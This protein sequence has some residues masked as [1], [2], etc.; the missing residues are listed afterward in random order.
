MNCVQTG[1]KTISTF[2]RLLILMVVLVASVGI[3]QSKNPKKKAIPRHPAS[4]STSETVRGN[5][6]P[7]YGSLPLSFEANQGQ[8]DAAV[9]YIS[10][11]DG[12]ALFLTGTGAVMALQGKVGGEGPLQKV[13][14]KT[15]N[16]WENRKIGRRLARLNKSHANHVLRLGL[17]GAKVD[18]FLAPLDELPGKSNYF[19][20]KDPSKWRSGVPNYARVRDVGVYPGVDLIYYGNQRQLEFDFVISPGADPKAIALKFGSGERLSVMRHGSLRIGSSP[21]FIV[22]HRPSIYQVAKGKKHSVSGGFR[23]LADGRVGFHVGL[24]NHSEPLI[25]DPVLSYSTFLS[26]NSGA[27][28]DGIAV[29]SSGNGYIAGSTISTD[30]PM[31]NAYQSGGITNFVAFL[32]KFDPT[33]TTLL[34]ST[35]LGG[36]GESYS[37]GVAIDGS[38]NAYV[39]GYTFTSAFPIVNGLQT[40]NNN[41]TGGNAFVARI[42][43][44]QVGI[45]SLVYSTYLG[46]GG[47]ASSWGDTGYGI[48]T[49]QQGRAYVTGQTTSDASIVPFPTTA[50]A[51]Q[52]SSTSSNGTAFLSVID[53]NLSGG[54]SLI[55]STYFGGDGLGPYGEFGTGIAVDGNGN[56]YLVGQTTSDSA[57]PFPTTPGAFQTSL[58]SPN[59]NAF[60]AEITPNASG[61]QSLLYS[62]YL[63]GSTT[64]PGGD[65]A[66]AIALDPA[67][68]VYVVGDTSSE[69]F[70]VTS[71]VFQTTNSAVGRAFLAKLDLSQQGTQALVYSTFLG[72]TNGDYAWGVTV[73]GSGNS[74]VVGQT[75]SSDFPTTSDALQSANK[76]S[77]WTGF[78][79]ELSTDAT[80]LLYSTYLGGTIGDVA[81][82]VALDQLGNFY[83]A[84]YTDSSDFPTANAFQSTLQ[85]TQGGFVT[86]FALR[87]NPSI[88]ASVIPTPNAGGWNN[89]AATV[90][91]TCTPGPVLLQT[92]SP[93]VMVRKEGANQ[94]FSGTVV[95]TANTTASTTENVS[96]DMTPPGIT[97]TSPVDSSSVSTGTVLVSGSIT[98]ALSGPGGVNCHGAQAILNGSAFSCAVQ[99]SAGSNSI[100]VIGTD[101]AGNATSAN[102]TVTNTGAS[103]QGNPPIVSA[104]SPNL[105]GVGSV[106]TLTG[107]GFGLS[108]NSSVVM[109]N[110]IMGRILGWSDSNISVG[111]PIALTPGPATVLV[112]VNSSASNTAQFTVT[113]PLFVTPSQITMPVSTTQALAL[114]DENGLILSAATWTLDNSSVAQIIPPSNGQPTQLQASASGTAILVGSS[115]NRTGVAQVTV[116]AAGSSLPVGSIQWEISSL[117]PGKISKA[118][119][120]FR[121]DDNTPDLY[122]EDDG[123]N[124][125]NGAI[126]ALNAQGQPKWIWRPAGTD[127]TALVAAADNL[128]GV[129]YFAT[130]DSPNQF[131]SYCYFGRLDENGNET[132]QYQETNCREDYAIHPDG[133]IFLVEPSFQNTNADVIT[134][135]DPNT[136]QIKFTIP[137]PG[138]VFNRGAMSISS[139]GTVYLPFTTNV[140]V[141][142]MAIQSDGSYTSRQLDSTPAQGLGRAIPDGQGGVLVTIASPPSLYHASLSGTSKFS[143]PIT[144]PQVI[145]GFL[146]DGPMLVG[147]DGTA[148]IVGSSDP[149]GPVDTVLA[150]NTLS[151]ALKWSVVPGGGPELSTIMADGS[152]TFRNTMS[153]FSQHLSIAFPTGTVAPLFTNS[154]DGSDVGPVTFFA[155]N[156]PSYWAL[157]TWFAFKNDGGFA[158][159]TGNTEFLAGGE[160]PRSGGNAQKE[161]EPSYCQRLKC[162]LAPTRDDITAPQRGGYP[163]RTVRYEIFSSR[164]DILN[165]PSPANVKSTRIVVL[166]TNPTNLSTF[167]CSQKV[168]DTGEC[169]SPNPNCNLTITASFCDP[170]GVYT[171]LYSAGNTGPNTV[172]QKFSIDGVP[173]PVYW[174]QTASDSNTYWY[175][176]LTQN[177]TVNNNNPN[178]VLILQNN[179]DSN[180]GMPCPTGCSPRRPNGS[181]R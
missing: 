131:D 178:A 167:I 135:L 25:I 13:G 144:P 122:L 21:D 138:D 89:S 59:G 31:E 176:A 172:T 104:V 26:G 34:Y 65:Y 75:A 137:A 140:D 160:Y 69:D 63:G 168:I 81:S 1:S 148:Y 165:V 155:Q 83:V 169:Q 141:Q 49:D 147:G 61:S 78:V 90:T 128:G 35:Y 106:V 174:P 132:W 151:G 60:V 68:R 14:A 19:I 150:M 93:P 170:P 111:V 86:K 105:G 66:S 38:G 23:L 4:M 77:F 15:R 181:L 101:L 180:H 98:D 99:L 154:A 117:G 173:T 159:V 110:G 12:Y 152:V 5:P 139:D 37:T 85:S 8:A 82:G 175:G 112:G 113:Q 22:L 57:G 80:S 120:G 41:V 116:L 45:S 50:S 162:V 125:G 44:T 127:N 67:G 157:N 70:P 88:T 97:I 94:S 121:I 42:D 84:G 30:F 103:G 56:A 163:S 47:N 58:N 136:G 9:N 76:N 74:F 130:M 143:L 153:D 158:A 33:G 73:N 32:S 16:K 10:H 92:C 119:Q 72:G 123:A 71:G 161:R 24:Y 2:C 20:G 52:S 96:L 54:T 18:A 102:V 39:T 179:P 28:A 79:S 51:Y 115:G 6:I 43:T 145:D 91:F 118:V 129:V 87:A 142:L 134:A 108:Q 109:F 3:A 11:G 55:Y 53:T 114:L 166:E 62:T 171:D 124:G 48:A 95:D 7:S 64:N 17:D 146:D 126:R 40:A 46:G 27:S 177:A 164:N 156:L 149:E 133:T 100:T 29:D 36:T 107:S